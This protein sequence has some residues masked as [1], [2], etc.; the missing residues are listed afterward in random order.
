MAEKGGHLR[1]FLRVKLILRTGRVHGAHLESRE[2]DRPVVAQRFQ[3]N[4]RI[5]ALH[6]DIQAVEALTILLDQVEVE[7]SNVYVTYSFVDL[8]R[9]SGLT[10][11]APVEVWSESAGPTYFGVSTPCHG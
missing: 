2:A 3:R 6:P 10:G 11:F 5:A 9:R 7:G 1:E 4:D 8:V